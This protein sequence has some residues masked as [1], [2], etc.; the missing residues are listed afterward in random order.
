MTGAKA[1][2]ADLRGTGIDL[3]QICCARIGF[4]HE[5][6][7]VQTG[8]FQAAHHF[9]RSRRHFRMLDATQYGS[10]PGGVALLQNLE[11]EAG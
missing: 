8:E 7:T 1:Q 6:K 4:K 5:V 3:D 2:M 9:F 11:M 10:V